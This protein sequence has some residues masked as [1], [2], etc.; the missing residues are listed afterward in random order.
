MAFIDH[1]IGLWKRRVHYFSDIGIARREPVIEITVLG[2]PV[3]IIGSAKIHTTPT[4]S[5]FLALVF[6]NIPNHGIDSPGDSSLLEGVRTTKRILNSKLGTD[7]NHKAA[8]L[9]SKRFRELGT[10][11]TSIG[12]EV[13]LF[14]WV[15][16]EVMRLVS[17][18]AYGPDNPFWDP[19]VESAFWEFEGSTIAFCFTNF[20][21]KWMVPGLVNGIH[22]R[23][24]VVKALD[25]YL[26][27][28]HLVQ[29]SPVVNA[30]YLLFKAGL[31]ERDV[32][33]F[34]A[35][36]TLGTFGNTVPIAFWL[37]YHIYSNVE[38]LADI[39]AM[40]DLQKLPTA[41][42]FFS[43]VEEVSR[44]RA[45]GMGVRVVTE[46]TI[47]SE[48]SNS[49]HLKKNG[50]IVIAN[51][52]L[53]TDRDVW[54]DTAESFVPGRFLGK[55]P[56]IS[57]R[58]FGNGAS[59]CCGKNFATYLIATFVALMVMRFDMEPVDGIWR[60]P[61][62][63]GRMLAAQVAGPVKS[64]MVKMVAREDLSKVVW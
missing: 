24:V 48:G 60:E 59:A 10:K 1:A 11:E 23:E 20:L 17:E 51:R 5:H 14:G 26:H 63:D 39:R 41:T 34:E 52:A 13:D 2:T 38:L 32:A 57:F 30:H 40:I 36:N 45:T 64:P 61:E 42:V 46:D 29:G 25:K 44:H 6:C 50:W 22:G 4:A 3:Y 53:H 49:Y 19:E 15:K 7:M 43:A 27:T 21:P 33:R 31:D 18:S 28:G 35:A 9:T 56:H 12:L 54:G 58:G 8:R 47:V 55:T 37:L 62:Q 16:H